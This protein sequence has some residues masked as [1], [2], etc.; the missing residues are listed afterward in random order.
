MATMVLDPNAPGLDE[1]KE[2]RR[3]SGLDRL[4]EVWEGTLHMVPAPS[5]EHASI[6]QQLA[7]ALDGPARAAAWLE[8]G[9]AAGAWRRAA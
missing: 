3:I 9:V 5:F 6:A 2:R 1:L 4:D 7:V 8:R